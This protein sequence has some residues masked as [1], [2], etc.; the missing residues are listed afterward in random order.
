MLSPSGT[1]SAKDLRAVRCDLVIMTTVGLVLLGLR[2]SEFRTLNVRWDQNA[3]GSIVW[4]LLGL[5]TAHL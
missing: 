4:I 1:R 5:H 2:A 3:Y